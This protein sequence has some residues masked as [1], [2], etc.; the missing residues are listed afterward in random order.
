MTTLLKTLFQDAIDATVV[1]AIDD[2]IV[3]ASVD[4]INYAVEYDI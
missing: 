2:T 4:A 3:S 1:N